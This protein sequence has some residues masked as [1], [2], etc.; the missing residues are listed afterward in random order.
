VRPAREVVWEGGAIDA[1]RGSVLS[2]RNPPSVS[3]GRKTRQGVASIDVVVK[4]EPSNERNHR[5][6]L[7]WPTHAN[8]W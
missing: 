3:E 4:C 6:G 1:W 7:E 2:A 5:T 8:Q